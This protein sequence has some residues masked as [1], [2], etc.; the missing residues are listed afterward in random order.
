MVKGKKE[1]IEENKRLMGVIKKKE[2]ME[3]Q[4]KIMLRD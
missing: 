4:R 2:G 3:R 1:L